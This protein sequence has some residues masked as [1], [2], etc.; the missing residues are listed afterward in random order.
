MRRR[1]TVLAV[2]AISTLLIASPAMA[3]TLD[4]SCDAAA[5]N[6]DSFRADGSPL[7]S[8]TVATATE[9]DPFKVDLAGSVAWDASSEVPLVDHTWGIGL[10]IGGTKAQFFSGGDPNTAETQTSTGEVSIANRLGEIQNS[11]MEWVIGELNG[12]LEAW[13]RIEAADGTF[14]D[15]TAW[16][17][18]DGSFGV[19]GLLGAGLAAA[20]GAMVVRAGV[21]KS[22]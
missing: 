3:G 7:D 4:G 11:M 9:S 12:K 6:G 21:K 1:L 13:G 20:G 22:A 10:I 16:V 5:V 14:C 15:G 8:K 17:E 2:A 18:I 19:F